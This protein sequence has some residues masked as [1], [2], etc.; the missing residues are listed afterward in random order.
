MQVFVGGIP[1]NDDFSTD[2][3]Q[4]RQ[5]IPIPPAWWAWLNWIGCSTN[6]FCFV[7]HEDRI[8]VKISH[9]R[10]KTRLRTPNR[11]E[12]A[13]AFALRGKIWLIT[14]RFG[15]LSL[16]RERSFRKRISGGRRTRNGVYIM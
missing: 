16:C 3:W 15:A 8:R 9:P 7:A 10:N 1:A 4:Y 5:S 14:G 6:S 11:E 13:S 2:V 12:R